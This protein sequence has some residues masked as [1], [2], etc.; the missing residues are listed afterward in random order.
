MF[1]P[2]ETRTSTCRNFATISSGLYRFL[3]I[4]V[5]LD[6]KDIPQV[7]PLQWGRITITPDG[8]RAY[9]ANLGARS[10]SVV[11]TP[12]NTVLA[13][14]EVEPSPQQIAITPDGKS[15]YVTCSVDSSSSGNVIVIDTASNTVKAR[16]QAGERPNGIALT[17]DGKRAY[18]TTLAGDVST[19]DTASN[20]II[21]TIA[22]A[23][24]FH[25]GV[26]NSTNGPR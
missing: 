20:S 8:K 1:W 12:S 2:C 23:E 21:A 4:T 10:V 7:G 18:V 11:D 17:R 16:I 5:L 9:V 25:F 3:A 13:T 26:F 22:V 15:A 19:I 24:L 6:V 14:V